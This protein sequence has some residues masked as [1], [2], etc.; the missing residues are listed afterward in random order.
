MLTELHAWWL[1]GDRKDKVGGSLSHNVIEVA[2]GSPRGTLK[3]WK[4]KLNANDNF[5]LAT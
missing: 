2:S 4:I 5:V 1:I 3:S